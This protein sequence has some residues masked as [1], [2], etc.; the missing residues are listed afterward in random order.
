MHAVVLH[1]PKE[2]N[3]AVASG[4]TKT[5]KYL[6]IISIAV[7]LIAAL[8]QYLSANPI[9]LSYVLNPAEGLTIWAILAIAF[10]LGMMHGATPDEHTWPITFSYSIGS[11][12]TRKGMKAG[13]VFSSGFTLQ[14]AFL[15]TL[16]YLGLAAIYTKYD[17]NGPVYVIV[18]IAMFIAGIY[19]LNKKKY[20]HLPFDKLLSDTDHH[21]TE[22]SKRSPLGKEELKPINLKL[23]AVHGLIAGFG[24]GAYA[25]I[26]TFI[27]APQVPGLIYAP[28]PGLAFGIG[29]MVMQI[30]FGAIFANFARLKKLTEKQVMYMGRK[31]AGRTLY[32]GG[33]M[34][35]LIGLLIIA[36]PAIDKIAVSTGNPIPNLDSIGVSTVLVL[37]VVGAI[38]IG[39]MIKGIREITSIS[40]KGMKNSRKG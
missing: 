39:S 2:K 14:R 6:L 24:F 33:A 19:I 9:N 25:S 8:Y 26:I 28:L 7:I 10:I 32:Y 4:K 27:L 15:T 16:G 12:S 38:G 17:L 20:L 21:H 36:F 22:D 23:A 31:T 11:Y 1:M 30:I 13:L 34:F 35:A 18:G 40:K 5:A 37:L 3:R 29:T